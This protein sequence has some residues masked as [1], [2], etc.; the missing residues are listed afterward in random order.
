M[1][2]EGQY[3][4]ECVSCEFG[5][6]ST[7]KEQAGLQFKIF[8]GTRVLRMLGSYRMFEGNTPESSEKMRKMRLEE[9]A[10]IGWDWNKMALPEKPVRVFVTVTHEADLQNVMRERIAFINSQNRA[11][12]MKD[13]MGEGEKLAF[14]ARMRGYAAA[15]QAQAGDAAEPAGSALVPSEP[16]PWD[17]PSG[18]VPGAA[19]S[20]GNEEWGAPPK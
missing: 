3:E 10:A 20:D 9:F 16:E 13:K 18:A 14:Q 15:A 8:E 1:L 5:K 2:P 4:A 11:L 19:P 12:G 6:T 17:T 7:N